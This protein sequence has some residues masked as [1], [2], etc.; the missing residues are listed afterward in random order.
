[1]TQ[2]EKARLESISKVS[3]YSA[4]SNSAGIKYSFTVAER[5][6]VGDSI[7]EIRPAEG[8]MTKLLAATGKKLTL[9]EGRIVSMPK[10]SLLG[11]L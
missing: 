5:H 9:V 10:Q 11:A 8:I 2:T 4:R 1:M 7:L 3:L 6:M